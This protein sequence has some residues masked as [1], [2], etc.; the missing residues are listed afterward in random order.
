MKI[1][2]AQGLDS[3]AA[4]R[5]LLEVGF[6]V[7]DDIGATLVDIVEEELEEALGHARD[8]MD[9]EVTRVETRW[10][11]VFVFRDRARVTLAAAKRFVFSQRPKP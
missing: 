7:V 2:L 9:L 3:R 11:P 1:H 8:E 4:A 6:T 10:G 5:E